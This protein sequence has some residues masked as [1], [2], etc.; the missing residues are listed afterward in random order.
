[1]RRLLVA[2]SLITLACATPA[3]AQ[4]AAPAVAAPAVAAPTVPKGK[5]TDAVKPVTYRLDLTVNPDNE[6][7][8][9]TV[10]IDAVLKAPSTFVD[11]HGRDLGMKK[12][13]ATA[14]GKTFT[15][16]WAQV[17]PTGVARLTFAE[18]LPAGPVTF[19]FDYDAPFNTGPAGLFRVKVG[20]DWYSWS[21]FQSIDAR[22]AFPSF[23]E[24]GF[25]QPFTVTLRTK[26]GQV[27]VSNAPQVSKT[28]ENGLEVHRFAPTLP[29]PTYLVAVMVGPFATVEGTV[30][31]TPQ[32]A[33]PLPLRIVTTQ[34]NKDK[35]TFALE[36]SKGIV[37]HL[38]AYFNQAFPYP[39]LDQI[40]S[41][42]MPGAME[43]A[44]ADLYAD[45]I[46]IMDESAPTGQKRAFGMVV[47]HEL[48]HQWFGD[49]VTPA[50]WDDI[51]LNESFAN[52]MGFRIG[53][54]WRPD[55]NIGAGA[56]EEGF[57]AMN[58]D[59]LVAG[60]A[61]HQPIP[62]N[63]QIDEAFDSIT[64][65]KGGHVVSMIA[66]YM[67]DTKFRDGVRR[68]MAAHRYGNATSKEFFAAMAEAAGDARIVPAMQS[69]TDQQGVP[70]VTFTPG[71]GGR[72]TATQ[73]RYTRLGTVAPDTRWGVP[74]CVRRL[75]VTKQTCQLLTDKSAPLALAGKGPFVPNAG[76][77]GY[78]RFELPAK[79]W[80][81]LIAKAGTLP[82]GEAQALDDS[83]FASFRAG[84]AAPE[85]LIASARELAKNKDSY[86]SA[87]GFGT[88][89]ALYG[90]SIM[91]E[92][93]KAGYRRLLNATFKPQLAAM[94]FNPA[95]GAYTK[96]DPEMSEKR[97]QIVRRL[98]NTA[99]DADLRKQIGDAA[100][101]YLAGKTD[102]L[103]RAWL[104]T[105]L[106]IVLEE[107][108][109]PK[110]KELAEKALSSQD[111]VFR[112]TVLGVIG[113]SGKADIGKWVLTE[114][115]DKRLRP[116]E[117]LG[118]LGGVISTEETR[119]MGFEWLKANLDTLTKTSGGGIF[120]ASRLPGVV[121]G[122]CSA[123]RADEIAA[124]MRPQLAGKT[125]ALELERTLERIRSCGKLKE[126]RGAEVSRAFSKL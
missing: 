85:L 34:Q 36:G 66:G 9:G 22:A 100:K 59:A 27:A 43:N 60:R 47:A 67:G 10:E 7:F 84:R 99:R 48:A 39:K 24:P 29:L 58:T 86:A 102:A 20:D 121:G 97:A 119:D 44:G 104:G 94:G 93:A 19:A 30:P 83:L 28:M 79:D 103:D 52:W 18:P 112:P 2:T 108:G 114:F 124:L 16:T 107:G 90:S 73:S 76:G 106:A 62:T 116:S 81:A 77:T 101:A 105:G 46:L 38:E 117:R 31:P 118:M 14:G 32:R 5:L 88:L 70:L 96:E 98:A 123:A 64:Y 6:R 74:L 21:Q 37:T 50:W 57:D 65:G 35:M 95:A 17:D 92:G 120:F 51:W 111:P 33:T 122:F 69:F 63:A 45:P 42:I 61:I 12:A 110:A 113:G 87:A 4:D 56:L 82:G 91:D 15:G 23:D 54:E 89:Q 53:G 26:P 109:L 125:G 25:K 78:Y 68:Y 3:L 1:M 71:K 75:A 8:N 11:L 49:L 115:Q 72:Y 126:A 80:A 13:V 55:L 40:T 41:P